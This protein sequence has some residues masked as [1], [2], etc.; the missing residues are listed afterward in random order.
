VKINVTK[1]G[2]KNKKNPSSKHHQNHTRK[3][4]EY[5]GIDVAGEG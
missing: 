3:L 4:Q 5:V 1:A 2:C